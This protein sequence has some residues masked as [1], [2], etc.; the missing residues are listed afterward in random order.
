LTAKELTKTLPD[1]PK[2]MLNL[3]SLKLGKSGQADWSLLDDPFDFSTHT[4]MVLSLNN[5]PL[6][7][8]SL[9]FKTLTELTL[10]DHNFDLHLDT[11]LDFLEENHSLER[12]T[13]DIGFARAPFRHSQ[14]KTPIGNQLRHLSISC[15]DVMDSRV[16]VS[17]IA[18]RK[19]AD[20]EIH[21]SDGR[22][23]L[24][25]LL[26][27]GSLA[28]LPRLSSLT[29]MEYRSFPRLIRLLG[30]GGSL[31]YKGYYSSEIIFRELL[32]FKWS[33]L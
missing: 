28:H 24:P 6:F 18:L 31:S 16:L 3:R 26:S 30:P 1:F 5:I 10:L 13:S 32:I 29:F 20:L 11:L 7:P 14:Y 23:R 15:Y 12:A 4:L 25:N 19:A 33:R 9:G 2:S 17:S 21:Y 22:R 8:S 27:G